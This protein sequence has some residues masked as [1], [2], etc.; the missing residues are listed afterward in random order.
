MNAALT[1]LA[2]ALLQTAVG[3]AETLQPVAALCTVQKE[4]LGKT[5]QGEPVESYTLTSVHGLKAKVMTWG[6]SLVEMHVPDRDGRL[7]DITLGLDK[8][9][10]YFLRHPYLGSTT[11]RYCNRIA[12]GRFTLDG[13]TFTLA[14]NNGPNHLHGGVKGFDQR[15]WRGEI[16]DH[17]VRFS[18]T[19]PDGEEGY[20]G[21][22]KVEVTYSF[23]KDKI[24]LLAGD[25]LRIDYHATTDKPTVVNLT[26]H[27][28]WNLKGA[29]E[30]D[31]LNHELTIH[32][33]L[34]TVADATNIPTGQ[35][36]AVAGGPLDFT[37]PKVI[38]KDFAK[39]AGTPG[40]Y[41]LNYVLDRE[42]SIQFR[43]DG[44]QPVLAAEV[45]EPMSARTMKIWTTEPCIQFY[46]GNNLDGSFIGKNGKP[47]VRNSGFCLETQH[48][49]D[50]P[51]HP[52]FP[53]TILRPGEEYKSTTIYSFSVK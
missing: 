38:A 15:N 1:F 47:I 46:T 34:S 18:S 17:S 16:I 7:A 32:A 20:P 50:S 35:L 13:Q 39:M 49:P 11:G 44:I 4:I 22:L 48:Y 27:A 12:R 8:L 41:D 26:N 51:N 28:Y 25:G 45:R 31:I 19:S 33:A 3:A 42:K 53:S 40:G 14:T 52:G 23:T 5:A 29:G 2:T 30:G 9:D 21:T 24:A 36:A 6:A 10:G 43:E 37:A